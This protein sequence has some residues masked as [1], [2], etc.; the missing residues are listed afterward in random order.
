MLGF[1][2]NQFPVQ[3]VGEKRNYVMRVGELQNTQREQSKQWIP[4]S[5]AALTSDFF[6]LFGSIWRINVTLRTPR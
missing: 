2:K 1:L 6:P 5:R 4:I 3:F